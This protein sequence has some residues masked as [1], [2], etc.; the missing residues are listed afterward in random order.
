MFSSLALL[1]LCC[2]ML[3]NSKSNARS[4]DDIVESGTIRIAV[5]NDYPP[6][7]FLEEN[8]AKGIDIDIANEIARALEVTLELVWMT[9]GETTEDDFRNYLWKG[10][11]IHRIKA[12]VMMRAP[13]DRS[14][15]QKR[16]DVG[17][18]VNELVHMFAPYHRESWQII[19]NTKTL[20]EVETMG[21]FQYHTIGAEI[22][23]IPHF[24]L[25]SAFGGRLR[26]KTS[27]YATNALAFDA[28]KI[29]EIEAVM[30]LRSQISY[31]SQF[32]DSSQ[33]KL[34]ANAFPLI[35]KQKWDIGLAVHNDYR[36]LS[37]EVGDVITALV[38]D[39]KMQAIFDKYSTVY[40]MPPYYQ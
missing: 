28:M 10:H 37:Y 25:T 24:Y 34:A 9:P 15:S 35:G 16:D 5:Y 20:P 40:E 22:D 11:I 6:F 2:A 33:F 7:S 1:L 17:L 8:E 27:H 31:L 26:E 19:H 30:G 23:S 39:G 12:D 3:T 29:G 21:M 4:L 32:V 38:I 14:F 18:L 13:N 36:A